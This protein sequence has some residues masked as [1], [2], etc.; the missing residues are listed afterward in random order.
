[1]NSEF[2]IELD[3]ET[4]DGEANEETATFAS[5]SIRAG[6]RTLT[7]VEDR[8]AKTTRDV[9]RVSAYP[10]ALWIAANWWRLRWE[11]KK[12]GTDWAMTHH[13][14]AAGSGYV[15]PDMEIAS[16]G[17]YLMLISRA[18]DE[19]REE[20]VSFLGDNNV[21][22]P[23]RQFVEQIDRFMTTVIGR[24][25]DCGVRNED[26]EQLWSLI[27]SERQDIDQ[28]QYRRLEAILGF[29]AEKAPTDLIEAFLQ[30]GARLGKEAVAE[31]AA[32]LGTPQELES[33]ERA[34]QDADLLKIADFADIRDSVSEVFRCELPW[35][36]GEAAARTVRSTIGHPD[37]PF[38]DST[39]EDWLSLPAAALKNSGS[40]KGS[41]IAAA[42][43]AEKD[44]NELQVTLRSSWHSGRRFELA[45]LVAD[46]LLSASPEDRLLPATRAATTRQ[47]TQRAFA[48]EFLLP[49][50]E[51]K[52]R[53]GDQAPE[54][55][56]EIESIADEYGVSPL[57]VRT[58][59]VAKGLVSEDPYVR[60]EASR[61]Q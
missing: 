40:S 56:E 5:L 34:L 9:I 13:L 31:A 59:L 2:E 35:Q 26:F 33:V 45:R 30:S 52:A 17:D 25:R 19:R 23:A 1:M 38:S 12:R 15:W 51:L 53:I 22:I 58:R 28:A 7:R 24:L 42:L 14:A 10:V 54:D 18:T 36:M 44:S 47:K 32:S 27:L 8:L 55:E 3:W 37:G 39:L 16:E 41:P 4:M 20:P 60:A 61:P 57:L 48:A 11:S 21:F 49:W 6:G 50:T 43:R 46:H 29:D